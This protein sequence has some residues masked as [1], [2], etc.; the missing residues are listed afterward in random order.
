MKILEWRWVLSLLFARHSHNDKIMGRIDVYRDSG[1]NLK[2]FPGGKF[3]QPLIEK[4]TFKEKGQ[5]PNPL[6]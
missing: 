4:E 1:K 2:P 5:T 3:Q 6:P